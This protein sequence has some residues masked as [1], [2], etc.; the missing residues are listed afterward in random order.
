MARRS[1]I[2]VWQRTGPGSGVSMPIEALSPFGQCLVLLNQ[3]LSLF[4]SRRRKVGV[5]GALWGLVGLAL[6]PFA[7]LYV[8]SAVYGPRLASAITAARRRRLPG[9]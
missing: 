2:R 1:G 7:T 3:F 5:F 6:L 8:F 4:V 9:V